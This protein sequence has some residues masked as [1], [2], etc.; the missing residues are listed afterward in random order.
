MTK[1]QWACWAAGVTAIVTVLTG[2]ALATP[3]SDVV[4]TILARSGFADQVDIMFRLAGQGPGREVLQVRDGQDTV[5]QQIVFNSGGQTGWHSHPGPALVLVTEGELTIYSSEDQTCSGRT[6]SAGQ[7]FIDP[8]QGHVHIG[9]ASQT[10]T[11]TLWVTYF[12][13]PPG[14]GVRIDAADPGVCAF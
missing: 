4:G 9:R 5:I 7:A 13:V 2:V 14:S 11:T 1:R 3:G 10:Q 8:G 12:D 6:Y